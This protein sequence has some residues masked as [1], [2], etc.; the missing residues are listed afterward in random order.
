MPVSCS[1][2]LVEQASCLLQF[3]ASWWNR[4]L[5]GTGI[6]PVTIPGILVEQ[7]SWWNRH[8][9]CYNCR[10]GRMPTPL[11]LIPPLSNAGFLPSYL[12]PTPYSLL[13]TPYSRFPFLPKYPLNS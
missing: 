3:P 4:H 10:A 13:P 12:L 9:A 7:A 5:G 11:M 2:I 6:L 1:S 8:L